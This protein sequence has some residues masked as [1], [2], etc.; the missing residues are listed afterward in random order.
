VLVGDFTIQLC[1]YD[2]S[3]YLSIFKQLFK[4]AINT[5]N[6]TDMI[7][8][9]FFK[10]HVGANLRLGANYSVGAKIR[11]KNSRLMTGMS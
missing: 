1:S 4:F 8:G 11:L 6:I 10:T 2:W 3:G 9:Q 7:R 5:L